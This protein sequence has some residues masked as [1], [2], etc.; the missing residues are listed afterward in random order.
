[1]KNPGILLGF[2]LLLIASATYSHAETNTELNTK[3]SINIGINPMIELDFLTKEDIY[4]IRSKYVLLHPELLPGSYNPS[5][6]VFGQIAS[7]KPWWGI[8][9]LSYYGD[10]EKS[11]EGNSEDSRLLVNPFLLVG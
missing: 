11:I 6:E 3:P 7:G 9:G 2:L 5:E 8:L 1:M 4:D 10:G